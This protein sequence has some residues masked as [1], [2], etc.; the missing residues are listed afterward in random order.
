MSTGKAAITLSMLALILSFSLPAGAGTI[1]H[2][3][4]DQ[5]TIQAG[6]DAASDGDTVLVSPGTYIENVNFNGKAITVTSAGGPGV[7]VISGADT[8]SPTVSFNSNETAAS[9][10]SGFTVQPANNSNGAIYISS[11][12]TV[13]S[14]VIIGNPQTYASGI[15]VQSGSPVIQGN[16]IAGGQQ[17]GIT[18]YSDNGIQ[19][20]GNVIASNRGPGIALNYSNGTDVLQQ[21]TIVGNA[22]GGFA[23]YSFGS[24]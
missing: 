3:P 1:L 4:A 9:V 16:L 11:S 5:P 7:T 21:N 23:F 17:G 22:G 2:V 13:S 18:A 14:N 24:G 12:P 8:Y 6:I 19:I 15:Y 10:L 20:S